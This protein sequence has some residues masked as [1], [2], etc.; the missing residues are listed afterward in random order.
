MRRTQ[1]EQTVNG[2]YEFIEQHTFKAVGYHRTMSWRG[3]SGH[4]G[5]GV[6]EIASQKTDEDTE[7]LR[8]PAGWSV[9]VANT[10]FKLVRRS[11]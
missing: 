9:V 4:I 1:A 6:R 3:G 2:D 10:E 5:V 11:S 7:G 8:L